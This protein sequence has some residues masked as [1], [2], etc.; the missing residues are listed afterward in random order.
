MI[1]IIIDGKEY[2]AKPGLT[3]LQACASIGI[4]IPRFCY[5]ERLSIAG[6]CRMCLVEITKSPKPVASCALQIDNGMIIKTNSDLVKKAREGVM[7]LLLANHPLDCPICDQGGECD[8]QDQTMVYG[9]DRGRFKEDKRVVEDKNLGPFIKTIMTRCIHCTRCIR[10]ANEIAG[11]PLL[12][13]TG[14]GGSME[15]GTYV[16][17]TLDSELSGNVIDLCPVGALTSKPFAFTARNWELRSV[18]SIDVTDPMGSNIRIDHRGGKVFR[19]IPRLNEEINEEWITDKIRFLYD[20]FYKQRLN[21]PLIRNHNGRLT[22]TNWQNAFEVITTELKGISSL[23]PF[24]FKIGPLVEVEQLLVFKDLLT[25]LG[26]KVGHNQNFDFRSDYTLG[27]GIKNLE[28]NDVVLLIGSAS[29][30]PLLNVRLKKSSSSLGRNVFLIGNYRDLTQPFKHLGNG[31]KS[32]F[33]ILQGKDPFC[34]LL[35][36]AKGVAI[37]FGFNGPLKNMSAALKHLTYWIGK[38]RC[39]LVV[40]PIHQTM[41]KINGSEIG[42]DETKIRANTVDCGNNRKHIIFNLGN[43]M[44]LRSGHTKNSSGHTFNIYLG[45]HGS[46]QIN[47]ADVVLPGATFIEKNSTYLNIEGRTQETRLVNLPPDLAREDWKILKALSDVITSDYLST[48]GDA[49]SKGEIGDR[50]SSSK[51][52]LASR[53]FAVSPQLLDLGRLPQQDPVLLQKPYRPLKVQLRP[54]K[55]VPYLTDPLSQNSKNLCIAASTFKL[56]GPTS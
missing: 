13:L 29:S 1:N 38:D 7:E 33:K 21:K 35:V 27:Y 54:F 46:G 56:G 26:I 22:P 10:F 37:L 5:H 14:R 50:S 43:E 4:T 48:A 19:I 6:N 41:A 18:N 31:P 25:K 24:S 2:R 45:H 9:S 32:I 55:R 40:A 12:G 52:M 49:N 42:I 20:S 53:E 28:Q 39:S 51:S 23:V 17:K 44:G 47:S 16:E 36:K 8:L 11:V 15:V 34:R 3:I 30:I